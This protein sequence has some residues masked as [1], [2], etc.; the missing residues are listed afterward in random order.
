[1][2]VIGQP[3]DGHRRKRFHGPPE[4]SIST[5]RVAVTGHPVVIDPD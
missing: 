1:M 5:E 4:Q 3:K 2:L